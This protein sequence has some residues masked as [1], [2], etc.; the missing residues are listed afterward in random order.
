MEKMVMSSPHSAAPIRTERYFTSHEVG[1]ILQVNPSSVVK[2][3][4]DGILPA[5][6]T[7]GGHRRV[8]ATEL[9]RFA[10]HHGMPVPEQL[11]SLATTRVL[12]IDDEPRFLHSIERA[13]KP[14]EEEIEVATVENGIDAMLRVGAFKPEIVLLDLKMPGLDG[15]EVLDRLAKN[16]DTKGVRVIAMSGEMDPGTVERCRNLGAESCLQKPLPTGE[17]VQMLRD[18]RRSQRWGLK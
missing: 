14:F 8:T 7:P 13:L 10:Q 5:F 2:W 15:F 18:M 17:L 4:N 9:V 6:R 3:I 16:P 12:V 1:D 11:K